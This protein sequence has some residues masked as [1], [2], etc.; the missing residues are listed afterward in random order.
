LKDWENQPLPAASKVRPALVLTVLALGGCAPS[1]LTALEST[2]AA[3]DS[4]T[5]ALGNWCKANRIADPPRVVAMPVT[6]DDA[7]LPSDA[8]ALLEVD[9]RAA[10]GYRHVR[11]DCGDVTLSEAH[12]WF[13]PAR[14]TP[15]MNATLTTTREPFGKVV[16]PLRF[17]R[18]RLESTRGRAEGCPAGTILSHRALLRLP[19]GQPISLVVECYQAR[20]L[21]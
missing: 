4:A 6:G 8:R 9:G 19:G 2:L 15:D 3:Q 17:T 18:E 16:S 21:R 5:T 14:L 1:G 13:V 12:N 20:A 7:A 10:L 11:L